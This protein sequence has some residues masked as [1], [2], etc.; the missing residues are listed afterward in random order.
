M[1]TPGMAHQASGGKWR[2]FRRDPLGTVR[3]RLRAETHR[4]YRDLR[5]LYRA[6]GFRWPIYD[7]C[8]WFLNRTPRKAYA[9]EKA[10]MKLDP[11]QRRIVEELKDRG[12]CKVGLDEL[13][14]GHRLNQLQAIAETHLGTAANRTLV[15]AIA[16][17]AG[18]GRGTKF[19]MVRLRGNPAVFEWGDKFVE[20][21]LSDRIL[22]PVCAYLGM[23]ARVVDLD[24]WCHVPTGRRPYA[25]QRW[26][27]DPDDRRLVK[28]FLYLRDVDE[29]TGPFCYIPG[30]HNGGAFRGIYPQTMPDSQ[31]PPDG[32]VEKHFSQEQM[33]T[34]T[35]KAGTVILCDTTGF[36][37]GGHPRGP[38]RLLFTAAYTSNAGRL[39]N[40]NRYAISDL[41]EASLSPAARYGIGH[42]IGKAPVQV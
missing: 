16:A 13:F 26:H 14:P 3:G 11:L 8:Y 6:V 30:S 7:L 31:Y 39:D 38:L 19:Y 5:K 1:V 4:L 10:R 36:H 32:E 23:F 41:Q 9:S 21:G 12:I 15:E 37:K 25:S 33:L 42:T 2:K 28:L 35:G 20:L 40:V 34:C 22:W 29:D 27:R 18:A 17:G 24:L